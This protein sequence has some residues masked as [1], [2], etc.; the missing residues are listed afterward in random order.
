MKFNLN[1]ILLII[2]IALATL[3]V[4]T[5]TIS[6]ATGNASY[7]NQY[8]KKDPSS[9]KEIKN[10]TEALIAF[11]EFGQLRIVTKPDLSR[12]KNDLGVTLILSPWVSYQE[13][14]KTFYEELSQKK[15]FIISLISEYFSSHTQKEL[16]TLGEKKVKSDLLSI[17]NANLVMSKISGLYFDDYIFIE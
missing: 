3:I 12:S 8:R 10:T 17:I 5:T 9:A 1:K 15:R 2:I 7:G 14:D 13:K 11:K 16:L 4:L 6:F